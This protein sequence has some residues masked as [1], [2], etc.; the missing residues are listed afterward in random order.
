MVKETSSK[1]LKKSVTKKTVTKT[2]KKAVP[3][4]VEKAVAPATAENEIISPFIILKLWFEGWKNTFKLHGRSSRFELWIFMLVNSILTIGIQLKCSYYMSSR[5]LRA[6]NAEGMSINTIENYITVAE[7]LF[8]LIILIPLFPLGSILIRRMH[9]I[10]LLAWR[11]YLEP[12]FMGM[13]V[14]WVLF[15]SLTYIINTDYVYTALLL[16]VCF[17]TILYAV[18]FYGIKFLIMTFFY[19]GDKAKNRY[20]EAQYNTDEHEE[21]ALNLSCFYFLFIFTIGLLYLIFAL[22]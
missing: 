2:P 10:G 22:I 14:L 17:V 9:D 16:N 6:A 11:N 21:W 20:G 19:R 12:M 4:K 13:V 3:A 7:T 8:Y 5:F 18:G 15:L 1:T